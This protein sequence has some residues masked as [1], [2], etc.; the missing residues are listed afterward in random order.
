M[1]D[2][3]TGLSFMPRAVKALLFDFYRTMYR[4]YLQ[5]LI[6]PSIVSRIPLGVRPVST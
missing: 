5:S 4:I 2:S 3:V 1:C 6:R